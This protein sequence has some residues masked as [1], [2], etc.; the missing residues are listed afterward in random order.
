MDARW[1]EVG[2]R[3][4]RRVWEGQDGGGEGQ[5]GEGVREKRRGMR[6]CLFVRVRWG[7]LG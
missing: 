6:E 2:E 5:D 1:G 3:R 4:L 7:V